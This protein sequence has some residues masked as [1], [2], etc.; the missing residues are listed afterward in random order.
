LLFLELDPL[1]RGQ[2][3]PEHPGIR[4]GRVPDTNIGVTYVPDV[5][6]HIVYVTMI[7]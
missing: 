4:F 1:G 3:D 2:E 5:N 6:T 7:A